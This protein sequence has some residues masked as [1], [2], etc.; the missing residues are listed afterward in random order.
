MTRH[1]STWP[2]AEAIALRST[3]PAVLDTKSTEPVAPGGGIL[4]SDGR[5]TTSRTAASAHEK[6]RNPFVARML[7]GNFTSKSP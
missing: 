1:G 2:R 4:A 3:G 5:R 7:S 6:R